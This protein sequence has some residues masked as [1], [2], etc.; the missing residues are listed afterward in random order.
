[1]TAAPWSGGTESARHILPAGS[2]DCHHHIYDTR[3]AYHPEADYRPPDATVRDY[4][5]LRERL[6]VSRSVIVQPSSYGTDNAC[7]R[8]ALA[9]FGSSAR[10]VA[11]IDEHTSPDELQALDSAGVRG[12][13]FNLA[14]P[15]GAGIE[16]MQK[17][18]RRVADLGWHVQIHAL[19]RDY[20]ALEKHLAELP[21]TLVIDHLGRIPQPDALSHPAWNVLRRLVDG[22]RAWIKISGLNHDSVDGEPAYADAGVLVRE[23]IKAAPQRMLWGTDWPHVSAIVNPGRTAPDD[24]LIQDLIYDW[25]ETGQTRRMIFADNPCELYGFERASQ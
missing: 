20:P 16:Q 3:F 2:V 19:G 6:G 5:Q 10:G 7:L 23:W 11:V 21:A 24:A 9:S 12:I 1:M 13:R 18:S 25:M 22:G 15:A 17:L 14:R 8:E 4:T